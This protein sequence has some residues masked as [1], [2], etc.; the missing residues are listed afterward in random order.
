[1]CLYIF[2]RTR[3]H[4]FIY[5]KYH[6]FQQSDTPTSSASKLDLVIIFWPTD[7]A[8]TGP[9]SPSTSV[10]P[11]T[12]FLSCLIPNAASISCHIMIPILPGRRHIPVSLVLLTY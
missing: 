5:H 2:I 3:L 9:A 12:D 8:P 4:I 6:Y 11:V 1:M 10:F 7:P